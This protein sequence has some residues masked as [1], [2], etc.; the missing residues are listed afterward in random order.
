MKNSINENKYTLSGINSRLEEVEDWI[1]DLEDRAMESNQ[2]Q[3][4]REKK[5]AK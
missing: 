5:N 2:S 1:S 4:M 3:Q